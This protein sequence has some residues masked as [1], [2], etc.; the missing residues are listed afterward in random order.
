MTALWVTI[1][2]PRRLVWFLPP[3]VMIGAA[4]IGYNRAYLGAAGGYYSTFDA[5]TFG[6]P[7][8]RRADGD[9]AEPE[10][11]ALRFLA[12][13]ADRVRRICRSRSSGFAP[14]RS[15]PGCWRRL[16]AHALLIST[17]SCWWAGHCFGPRYWTEVIPLLAIVLGL[18]LAWARARCRP[19]YRGLARLDRGLN[20]RPVPGR[21]RCIRAD[22][23][24]TPRNDRT[25]E[26]LWDWSDSE[27][28]RCI[29]VS[30]AYRACSGRRPSQFPPRTNWSRI[31]RWRRHAEGPGPLPV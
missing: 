2:H 4:L 19:I 9:V 15:C 30:R 29:I 8:V 25:S 1:R 7:V 27:L 28:S 18:A 13:D 6:D 23:K 22:G 16:V 5:A 26:R 21:R 31:R 11:R 12:V 10:P 3:A 20:R 24:T 14:Q 17:F